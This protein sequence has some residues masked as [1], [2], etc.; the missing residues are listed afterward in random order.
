MT[1][2]AKTRDRQRKIVRNAAYRSSWLQP[3]MFPVERHWPAPRLR[4][5][6]VRP[7]TPIVLSG[8]Q[9]MIFAELQYLEHYDDFHP[10]LEGLLKKHFSHV[11]SGQQG[12]SWFWILDGEDKVA[13]DTF[14]SMKHQI[15]AAVPGAHVRAVIDAL[16]TAFEVRIYDAPEREGHEAS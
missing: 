15:K 9:P 6:R 3:W 12:D 13:I 16:R 2:I 8:M 11:E 5:A 10:R 1:H 4:G 7:S 14:T